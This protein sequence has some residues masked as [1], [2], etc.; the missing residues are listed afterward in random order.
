[1]TKQNKLIVGAVVVLGVYYLYDRNKKMKVVADLKAGANQPE[2]S[3][4]NISTLVPS[5]ERRA[6][7]PQV[8]KTKF[9]QSE[10]ESKWK[11][12]IGKTREFSSFEAMNISRDNYVKNCTGNEIM[13]Y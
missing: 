10:C 5:N 11:N 12:E 2:L 6:Y 9:S 8:T 1:M 13:F 7:I 4:G 3:G